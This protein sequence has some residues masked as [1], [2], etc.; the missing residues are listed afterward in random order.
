MTVVSDTSPLCY[1]AL[2]GG[3]E[4]LPDLFGQVWCPEEVLNECLHPKAPE[5]LRLWASQPPEWLHVITTD[6]DGAPLPTG[7]RL[8]PGEIAA[9]HLTR[10]LGADFILM[11]ER[12]GRLVAATLGFAVIGTL[13]I[14]VEAALLKM[15]DFEES[16]A[17]LRT[18]TNFRIAE[19]VVIAARAYLE[20]CRDTV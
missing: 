14:L 4:W 18:E 10:T 12:K 9:L 7:V 13:G 1:L 3:L 16:L 20:K 5:A 15:T 11:D 17:K 8:D 19:T 6:F 2:I